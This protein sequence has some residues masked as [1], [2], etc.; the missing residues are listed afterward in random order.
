MTE[1]VVVVGAGIAGMRAAEAIRKAG[2]T[3]EIVAVGDDPRMPYNRPPL[4]KD[5]LAKGPDPNRLLF[6]VPKIAQDVRWELGSTVVAADL[7]SR[8][9]T[10]DDGT[11]RD[12]TGLVIASGLRPRRLSLPGPDAGRYVVRTFDDCVRL[13]E[14]LTPGT[15]LVIVGA[16]FVGC[17][18]AATAT[19]LGADV[20]IVAPE[21]VPVERPLQALVGKAL[22]RRHEAGGVRFALG[23]VPV[24]YRGDAAVDGVVLAD[25]AT[26][27]ADIVVEAVGCIP[28]T[29]WLA[30]NDIDLSDGVLADNWL[31]VG[32]RDD[33]VA[34][35]DVARFP[36]TLVDDVPR[37]VE[38]W[39]MAADTGKRAGTTL[40]RHLAGE[41]RDDSPFAPVPSFWSD[42][43][44]LRLQSF[45]AVD[46]G[47]DDV[48]VLEGDP[49]DAELAVGYHRDGRLVGVVLIGL[50]TRYGHYRSLIAMG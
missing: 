29:E 3:G 18:L 32:D 42:Q 12:W 19:T 48:R 41:A 6:R 31:R 47:A 14:L 16:G 43:Y 1:R 10:L 46:L 27:D 11:T 8:T 30:G 50:A 17:E 2:F 25:G 22:R 15:K 40:G 39:T 49:D 37:R 34:C 26:L 45:G 35:G 24:G 36:N 44:D 21:A 5:A 38:H 20:T 9:V 33:V 13:R 4:T 7:H 28:N 23:T